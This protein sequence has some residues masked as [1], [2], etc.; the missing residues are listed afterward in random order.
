MAL[1]EP[2]ARLRQLFNRLSAPYARLVFS[3]LKHETRADI[4]WVRPRAGERVLDIACG[5]GTLVLEL[6]RC[7]CR[8]YAVDLAEQMIAR[9]HAAVRRQRCPPVLFAVADVDQLPLPDEAFDLVTC[10]FSFAVFPA[11]KQAIAEI[12]RVTR[13]GGRVAIVEAVA[14]E[15]SF[16]KTER[17]RLEQLRSGGVPARVLPLTE[18]CALFRQARLKLLDASV[19][20]RRRRLEDWLGSAVVRGSTAARQRLRAELLQTARENSAGLHLERHRGRWFFSAKVAR[21]LW[22]KP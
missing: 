11:P 6:A 4:A 22:R 3:R 7:A 12:R 2:K 20:E 1:Q 18:L 21:L 16:Q 19:T 8:V 17:D 14:P 13:R 15:D 5:P 10:A 9:A